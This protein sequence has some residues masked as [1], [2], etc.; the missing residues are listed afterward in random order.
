MAL[1]P[2]DLNGNLKEDVMKQRV[3]MLMCSV[4]LMGPGIGVCVFCAE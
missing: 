1:P 3:F 2:R 4:L